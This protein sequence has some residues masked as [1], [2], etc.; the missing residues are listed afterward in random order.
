M[1]KHGL[2]NRLGMSTT[3]AEM[4]AFLLAAEAWTAAVCSRPAS[5]SL[6]TTG[7]SLCYKSRQRNTCNA[8]SVVQTLHKC[9]YG[10]FCFTFPFAIHCLICIFFIVFCVIFIQRR[11]RNSHL[12]SLFPDI[13][14]SFVGFAASLWDVFLPFTVF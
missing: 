3:L 2:V 7:I 1:V 6:L 14:L 12:F 13:S 4:L 9:I 11:Q 10:S 8:H 5:A